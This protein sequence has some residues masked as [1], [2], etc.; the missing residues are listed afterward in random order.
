MK[1]NL[2]LAIILIAVAA[3]GRLTPHPW[4]VAPVAAAALLAGAVMPRK[5][6]VSVPLLA[7]LISDYF[8]GAYHLP[9]ML[10]VYGCFAATAF[11]GSWAAPRSDSRSESTTGVSGFKFSHVLGAM[12]RTGSLSEPSTGVRGM[13]PIRILIASLSSSTI[14]FLATNFAVW[15]SADWYEKSWSGLALAYTLAIPFFRNTMLGDLMFTGVMFGVWALAT[16]YV[17]LPLP[18]KRTRAV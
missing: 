2:L 3:A 6:A 1:R 9:V 5:W 14:F 17:R 8:L 11:I 12:P 7:M 18:E 10:T 13:S 15:A 16:H 4:N